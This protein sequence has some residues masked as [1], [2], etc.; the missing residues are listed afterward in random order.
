MLGAEMGAVGFRRWPGRAFGAGLCD[1]LQAGEQV[2]G[3]AEHSAEGAEDAA[4]LG[5]GGEEVGKLRDGEEMAE[6]GVAG[7]GFGELG[8]EPVVSA[9]DREDGEAV[10]LDVGRAG[11]GGGGALGVVLGLG[12]LPVFQRS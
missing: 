4:G 7:P 5:G 6:E 3:N 8:D 9:G 11:G 1:R 10:G 12:R 2:Q